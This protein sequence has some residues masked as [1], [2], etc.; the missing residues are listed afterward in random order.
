ME[1]GLNNKA[2]TPSNSKSKY[3]Y[4]DTYRKYLY[5]TDICNEC[6]K[7]CFQLHTE[8]I[9]ESVKHKI[10]KNTKTTYINDTQSEF[11]I[12][13]KLELTNKY[14]EN[15]SILLSNKPNAS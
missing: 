3:I 8:C 11:N 15:T 4:A 9:K 14:S 2:N 7:F 1:T 10:S 13:S 12:S 5:L 6:G